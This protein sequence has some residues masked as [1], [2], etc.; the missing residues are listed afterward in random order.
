MGNSGK[1][2]NT[3][4]KANS[5]K[6]GSREYLH[7]RS[8]YIDYSLH[9]LNWVNDL[10]LEKTFLGGVIAKLEER[11]YLRRLAIIAFFSLLLAFLLF[12]DFDFVSRFRLV[13]SSRAILRA[14]YLLKSSMRFQRSRRNSNR[15]LPL[16]PYL[17]MIAGFMMKLMAKSTVHFARGARR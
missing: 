2:G 8:H 15:R 11:F 14:L 4:S 7:A 1:S 16:S 9:F 5:G 10:G 17:T 12:H 3:T 13:K 6:S